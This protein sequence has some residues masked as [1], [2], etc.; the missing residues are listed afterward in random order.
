MKLVMNLILVA[1][2]A[3]ALYGCAGAAFNRID[4]T[5]SRNITVGQEL[6]DLQEA[7]E[8]GILSDTEYVEAKEDILNMVGLM[9][10]LKDGD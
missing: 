7:H 9:G 3:L 2:M 1:I 6:M 8:K 10:E 4:L 5:M